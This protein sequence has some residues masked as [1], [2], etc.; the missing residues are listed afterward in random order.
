MISP[1]PAAVAEI[2]IIVQECDARMLNSSNAVGY[3]KN[4]AQKTVN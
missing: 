3:I 2:P 4:S 1:E